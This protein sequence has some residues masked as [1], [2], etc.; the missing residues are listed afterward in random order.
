LSAQQAPSSV[1]T[2]P[3]SYSFDQEVTWYFDL[4][5]NDLV[6]AGDDLFFYSW[7][8]NTPPN[9]AAPLTY[10]NQML[11][12]LTFVPTDYYGVTLA[13][14][15]AAGSSAFWGTL[16]NS[17]SVS[18]TGTIPYAIKEQ[19]RL[20][21]QCSCLGEP[22]P[23]DNTFLINFGSSPISNPDS[24]SNYWTNV[25]A[26][27]STYSILDINGV[28][29]YDISTSGNFTPNNNSGFTNPDPNILGDMA[30]SEATQSYLFLSG[31]LTGTVTM[32]CLDPER[33]YTLSIFGSRNAT[34]VRETNYTV[35]GATVSQGMLQTSGSG[36]ATNPAL[37]CNDDEFYVVDMY[38]NSE[39][40]IEIL[41]E[42]NSGGY[43]YINMLKVEEIANPSVIAVTDLTIN[44][45]NLSTTGPSQLSIDYLPSNTTQTGVNWTVSDESVAI[46]DSSGN[47]MPIQE[48]TVTV[49]ATSTF[50][51]NISDQISVTFSNLTAQLYM[52]GT[53]TES[54]SDLGSD[55]LPMRVVEGTGGS[56]TNKFELYTSLND[57]GNIEFFTSQDG[58]G[59]Q[60]GGDGSGNL[61]NGAGNAISSPGGGWYYILVDLENMTYDITTIY[62]FNVI[63]NMLPTGV[64]QETWWGGA[65][66]LST[67]EGGSVWS[68][69]LNFSESTA[70]DNSP[71]FYIEL[72]GTGRT[73]KQIEGTPNSLIFSDQSSGVSTTDIFSFNGEY[74]VT[75]DMYNFT[76]NISNVCNTI[77]DMKISVMG[78]SVAKG[79]GAS[80]SSTDNSQYMGYAHQYD[81]LLQDRAANG[82]GGNFSISNISIGGDTTVDLLNRF[83]YHLMTDCGKY[84]VYGLSLAN[85]GI[86]SDAQGSFDQFS[87]NMQL[88]IQEAENNGKVPVVIGNY[89]NGG[90]TSTHYEFIKDMNLLIHGWDVPSVNVM[91]TIDN[92][93]G[94]WVTGYSSDGGHPNDA[95]YTEMMYSIVPSLFDAL[96]SGKPQPELVSNTWIDL[97]S[98]VSTMLSITPEEEV[99]SFSVSVDLKTNGS[100]TILGLETVDQVGT[101]SIDSNTGNI[102]F[103]SPNG[104]QVTGS[105]V[106]NDDAWHNITISHFYARGETI[107]FVDGIS[108]GN[109]SEQFL[110]ERTTLNSNSSPTS[111]DYR[112]WM[113]YRSGLNEEE[114]LSISNGNLLKSSLEIYA[115]LDGQGVTSNDVLINLAQSTNTVGSESTLGLGQI[116]SMDYIFNVSPN[117]INNNSICNYSIKNSSFVSFKLFNILG[118]EIGSYETYHESPGLYQMEINKFFNPSKSSGVYFLQIKTS[119]YK[120]TVRLVNF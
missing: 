73:I 62:G 41:T 55:G 11:W 25:E 95:G 79:F 4:T 57:T 47:L 97:G 77:D 56:F 102:V 109:L 19:L 64:G 112:D 110:L 7:E 51:A 12:S 28:S 113:F 76:Y 24:N 17:N 71:R 23:S 30:I 54:G 100:G 93:S 37:N 84:V 33:L 115:P 96:D 91:G 16:T 99:H 72:A 6:T 86:F 107:L 118:K 20:G 29:R 21:T 45:S 5:G 116:E 48:G 83:D 14:L 39:G 40:S 34:S 119:D 88:L 52:S 36:I 15:E 81:L 108:Q 31:T 90:Y 22:S 50:D 103:D 49:T 46:I 106:V 82:V 69:L 66:N 53:G 74:T 43:G 58:T 117:P 63:S 70:A 114:A 80:I 78:S 26:N 59:I 87:S 67:Y 13:D 101:I 27:N 111:V 60:Y 105:T 68:G 92:G 44:T 85:E 89:A 3:A 32:S 94:Q 61:I 75:V 8:P 65:E 10:E 2:S 38:P 9:G 35:T 120:D 98:E 104:G 42:I 1:C 18:V